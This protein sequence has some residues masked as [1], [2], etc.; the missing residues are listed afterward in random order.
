ML[1]IDIIVAMS[2]YVLQLLAFLLQGF[3][4]MDLK[5]YRLSMAISCF[6]AVAIARSLTHLTTISE[7]NA[8]IG[9]IWLWLW[10][11]SGGGDDTKKRLRKLKDKF[12]PVRRTA[13]VSS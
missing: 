12:R 8:A 4:M 3:G 7:I 10:W 5:T 2:P 1:T 13:P 6:L 11:K 9:V